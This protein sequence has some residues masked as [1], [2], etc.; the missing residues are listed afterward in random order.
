MR[1]VYQANTLGGFSRDPAAVLQAEALLLT[2]SWLRE[3]GCFAAA[4]S[5][6]RLLEAPPLSLLVDDKA[7]TW[8]FGALVAGNIRGGR[9]V[10]ESG[11]NEHC[12]SF[13][14][15]T[16]PSRN[17]MFRHLRDTTTPCGSMVAR[18]G[19]VAPPPSGKGSVE[20]LAPPAVKHD[21][22]QRVGPRSEGGRRSM[23]TPVAAECCV[24]LGD[25]PRAWARRRTLQV[26]L[27]RMAPH[28]PPVLRTV[29][30]RGYR[31]RAGDFSTGR[32][33]T[34]G[35]AIVAFRTAEEARVGLAALDGQRVSVAECL[36]EE[37]LA[38]IRKV[39]E[40]RGG[41]EAANI[42][43]A[44]AFTLRARACERGGALP[45]RVESPAGE[46]PPLL[47]QLRV[48]P[49]A[50]LDTR[51][52][53]L[54][55]D[56]ELGA[57]VPS[58]RREKLM[59]IAHAI[60]VAGGR[61]KV[62]C[63]GHTLPPELATALLDELCRLPWPARSERKDLRAERYLV[64][65][66]APSAT[67]AK[68]D[69]AG[70]RSLCVDL[71]EWADPEYRCSGV[72]VTKNFVGSPHVD[73][74]DVCHQYAISLGEFEGGELCIELDGGTAVAVVNTRGRCAR[75]DG[76]HVHWVRTFSG[77]DRYSLIFYDTVGEPEP[78]GPA[79]DREWWPRGRDMG[80]EGAEDSQW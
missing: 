30:R 45:A 33:P 16:F 1:Y 46:D 61:P 31:A 40:K 9:P 12:C 38:S 32:R 4:D 41:S 7:K 71:L 17:R 77:G 8:S 22:R 15:S 27:F 75:V 55:V 3:A 34:L 23:G 57:T 6:L 37:D 39:A 47:A 49:P 28:P 72:A 29:V 54:P 21:K 19:G 68:D 79:V 14:G 60:E 44:P 51:L 78:V 26:L 13:C 50:E 48:L 18:E 69:Y 24:W 62:H 74:Q 76:R 2:R 65:K 56:G 20:R 43:G 59:R 36:R 64:L 66:L 58:T 5:L 70:L 67:A 42:A 73:L 35:Y 63:A 53:A 25:I 11:A 52:E 80:V 10:L